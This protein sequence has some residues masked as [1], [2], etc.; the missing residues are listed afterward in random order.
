MKHI[1]D[2]L[3]QIPALPTE[4][5]ETVFRSRLEAR[6]AV[7]FDAAGIPWVYEKEGFDLGR[8]GCYLPD[9]WL[10]DQNCWVE[11]KGQEPNVREE[12]V[13]MALALIV[14]FPVYL[15]VGDFYIRGGSCRV[16]EAHVW[17]PT[18]GDRPRQLE[19]FDQGHIWCECA[20]CGRMGIQYQGRSARLPCDESCDKDRSSD[21]LH[22]WDSERLTEAYRAARSYKF[23]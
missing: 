13:A 1:R 10:P 7:F 8:V 17:Q 12:R 15:F 14:G 16:P 3:P 22:N 11:I 19:F 6:W 2:I 4:Y 5:S 18:S 23:R 21:R 20:H 9:F